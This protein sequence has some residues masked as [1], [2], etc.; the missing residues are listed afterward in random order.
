MFFLVVAA[1]LVGLD[2]LHKLTMYGF[3]KRFFT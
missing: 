2:G 3:K 1:D